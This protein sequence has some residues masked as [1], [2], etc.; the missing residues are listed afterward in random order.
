M[1]VIYLILMIS[2]ISIPALAQVKTYVSILPQKYFVEQ[3]GGDR[4]SVNV[5]V[6]P[7]ASPA[8]YEPKPKQMADLSKTD[9]YF[10][11]GVP[12]ERTWLERF[13]S[14]NK[15]MVIAETDKGI[16][17]REI[18][19]HTHH[20]EEGHEHEEDHHDEHAEHGHDDHGHDEHAEH[21]DEHD[22]ETHAEDDHHDHDHS[23]MKD[24][25]IWVDPILAVTQAHNIAEALCEADPEGCSV[26]RANEKAFAEK[27][28]KL[29]SEIKD[30]LAGSKGKNLLVF[31][32]SWGYFTDRYGLSQIPVELDGKEPKPADL[33]KFMDMVKRLR[34][35]TIFIQPQFSKKSAELIARETGATVTAADPLAENWDENLIYTAKLI[36]GTH[37]GMK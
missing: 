32:P 10:S 5:M 19:S 35:K 23:G 3:I 25:H 1:R 27:A 2:I 11:I 14:L 15:K 33:K 22:H 13:R 34:L 9:I 4:V 17:K 6:L 31:H 8:T 12:F 16:R 28:K 30:I 7:G 20:G 36:A 18:E 26:F 24:P 21:N 29:D 37:Q